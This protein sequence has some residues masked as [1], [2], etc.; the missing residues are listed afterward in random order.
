M[1]H[2]QRTPGVVELGTATIV[3][4]GQPFKNDPEPDGYRPMGLLAD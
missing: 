4:K 1:Q 3:T 2:E